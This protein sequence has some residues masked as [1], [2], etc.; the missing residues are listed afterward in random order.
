MKI[1]KILAN[2]LCIYIFILTGCSNSSDEKLDALNNFYNMDEKNHFSDQY[3]E[4][5]YN[6]KRYIKSSSFGINED[7]LERMVMVDIFESIATGK[8][9][10]LHLVS[11]EQSWD[12]LIAN[13]PLTPNI[14]K[15][16]LF[17]NGKS[18]KDK[19]LEVVSNINNGRY[20]TE[21][22]PE[23]TSV[24]KMTSSRIK[25][26]EKRDDVL[27]ENVDA[28]LVPFFVSCMS[29]EVL[30]GR[31]SESFEES[32]RYYLIKSTLEEM[33]EFIDEQ[34]IYQ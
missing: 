21:K 20:F 24:F 25:S 17:S 15:L 11:G 5:C 3:A 28:L 12:A 7:N 29:S 10:V 34:S 31:Q 13:Y 26:G 9:S 32:I 33:S 23:L 2:T 4:V 19:L 1:K 22:L 27:R 30:Y 14:R 18:S 16:Y 6:Y 8:Q